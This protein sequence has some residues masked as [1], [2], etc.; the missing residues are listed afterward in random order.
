MNILIGIPFYNSE[1]TLHLAIKSV[2]NQTYT[3]W[4]LIL[5]N[6]GSTDSSVEIAKFY[7][8][9]DKRITLV[10]DGYN[11]GLVF[12]LNQIIEMSKFDLIARM[13]AD[14]IMLPQRLEKQI[15]IFTNNSTVDIVAT[16]IYTIDHNNKPI[17]KRDNFPINQTNINDIFSKPFIVHPTLLVKNSWYQNN[18]YNDQYLRAEDYELWCRSFNHTN[19]F[20][21]E[22]P[23]LIYREG[24]VNIDNYRL[25]M[26]SVRKVLL[27]YFNQLSFY[28][29]TKYYILTHI[30]SFIYA[31]FGFFNIQFILSSHRNNNLKQDEIDFINTYIQQLDDL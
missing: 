16:A 6:D 20:R 26:I 8:K 15:K 24:N 19:F 4:Q 1:K 5:L 12:R 28:D 27:K 7:S 2:I 14:D 21:I 23:L 11:K 22:E 9:L 13:D 10:D 18:K 30:K 31:F 29:F 17:G 3:N 25:S